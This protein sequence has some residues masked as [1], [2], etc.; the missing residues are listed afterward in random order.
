MLASTHLS[1]PHIAMLIEYN[2]VRITVD[3]KPIL[4]HVNFKVDENDFIYLVGKVG[5]GKSS[6]LKSLYA[7][8]PVASGQAKILGYDLGQMKRKHVPLLRQQLGIVFQDFQLLRDRTV[9]QN[10]DFVLRCIGWKKKTRPTRIRQVL[11]CVGLQGI[12]DMFPH[13]L[14]GGEQQRVCIARALLNNP[15]VIIA[16]EPTANLD[17]E[18]SDKIMHTLLAAREQGTAIV[19]V[20]HNLGLLNQYPGYVYECA[21]GTLHEAGMA[22]DASISLEASA[23]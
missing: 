6:L 11:E 17:T 13:E 7:E 8:L 4:E 21:D 9:G 2:D 22:Q 14:S 23:S 15:K 16:D 18:N 12:E 19:M 5:T 1:P 10:L 20:T 3:S